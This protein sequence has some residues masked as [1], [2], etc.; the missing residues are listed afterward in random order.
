VTAEQRA[1]DFIVFCD[2]AEQFRF[3]DYAR[4]GRT[5]ARDLL[6]TLEELAVERSARVAIQAE[7]NRFRELLIARG[8]DGS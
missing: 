4:R 5:I 8:A 6:D 7:R 1:R 3:I 2:A